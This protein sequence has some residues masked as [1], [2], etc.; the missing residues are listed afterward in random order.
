MIKPGWREDLK[1]CF[2]D[3]RILEK[4]REEALEHFDQL[5]DFVIEPAFEDLTEEFLGYQVKTKFWK[6]RGKSIHLEIRFPKSRIDQFHYIL[7]MPK[8]SVELKLKL[9]VQWRKTPLGKLEEKTVPFVENVSPN[10][11]LKIDKD[12]F[13]QDVIARYKKFLYESAV[14]TE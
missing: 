10:E 5:C 13:A 9:T 11:I 1:A 4:C 2:V 14:L 12:T 7:W 8:N 6:D 3:T